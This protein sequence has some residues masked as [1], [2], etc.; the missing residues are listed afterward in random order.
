MLLISL[1]KHSISCTN[2]LEEDIN[3]TMKKNTKFVLFSGKDVG[4]KPNAGKENV[5]AT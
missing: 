4:L 1:L 2:I 3:T 5:A